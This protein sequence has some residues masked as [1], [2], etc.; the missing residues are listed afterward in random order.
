MAERMPAA[1]RTA[2]HALEALT[3]TRPPEERGEMIRGLAQT[4]QELHGK[5]GGAPAEV[6]EAIIRNP[7]PDAEEGED[8]AADT[9]R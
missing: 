5:H 6:W 7:L 1:E 3:H 4:L 8:H 2:R 9:R